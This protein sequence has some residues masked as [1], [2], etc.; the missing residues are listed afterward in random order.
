MLSLAAVAATLGGLPAL[1]WR[2]QLPQASAVPAS[3]LPQRRMLSAT[4]TT[5]GTVRLKSGAQVRVGSQVSGVVKK[6]NVTVGSRIRRGE[7]IAEIDPSSLAAKVAQAKAQV[8]VDE[9]ARA[10][11]QRDLERLQRLA[12][13]NLVPQQQMEDLAWQV[14]GATARLTKS[15]SDLAAAQVDL[16]YTVVRAPISGTVASVSTQQGETVAA[17]LNAP[18]FVTIIEDG[19]LELVAMVD[20]TDIADV[21][22][23][24]AMRY[25][26]EAQPAQELAAT[27]RRIDPTASILSGVVNYPVVG[28]IEGDIGLLRPDMTANITIVTGQRAALFIPALAVGREGGRNVVYLAPRGVQDAPVKRAVRTGVRQGTQVE[29]TFGLGPLERILAAAPADSGGRP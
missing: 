3:V 11:A 14:K 23:G 21:R 22:P 20:E 18:T 10:K 27:V 13:Q 15:N 4:V 6:L 28:T 19:A 16:S 24:N 25:T 9:V 29:V 7:V 17:S 8:A 12:E 2:A 1:L 5:N 26:V